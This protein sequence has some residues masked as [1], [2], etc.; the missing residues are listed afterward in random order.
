[1]SVTPKD[2]LDEFR[3]EVKDKR[4]SALIDAY[5]KKPSAEAM[6]GKALALLAEDLHA[7]EKS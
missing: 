7:I 6:S 2:L 3:N 4:R 5:I 1:M